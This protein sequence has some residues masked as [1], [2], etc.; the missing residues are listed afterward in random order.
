MNTGYRIYSRILSNRLKNISHALLLEEQ[1]GFRKGRSCIDSIFTLKQL[2]EKRRE[3]NLETH[4]AFID[5]EKAFDRVDREKLWKIMDYMG[6]P[7][8]TSLNVLKAY[9]KKLVSF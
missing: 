1:N 9:I 2:F 7:P 3:F 6:Y 8:L 4:V 5:F